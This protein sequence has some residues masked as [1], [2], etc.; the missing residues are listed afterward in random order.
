MALKSFNR[1]GHLRTAK[2]YRP[3]SRK[4]RAL[5]SIRGF[6][7][8]GLRPGLYPKARLRGLEQLGKNDA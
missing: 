3:G 7:A 1:N 6:F 4:L 2:L 5:V 8:W